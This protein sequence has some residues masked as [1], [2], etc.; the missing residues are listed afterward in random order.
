MDE[1]SLC[2]ERM[3]QALA[4]RQAF[5]TL[6]LTGDH[7]APL[8]RRLW[9]LVARRLPVVRPVL[10]RVLVLQLPMATREDALADAAWA[11]GVAARCRPTL[12][13]A[14]A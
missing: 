5:V 4:F 6:R 10:S 12:T 3:D 8:T 11:A 14:L 2:S 13:A 7:V 9:A 1:W